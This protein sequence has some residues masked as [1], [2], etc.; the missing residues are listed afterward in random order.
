MIPKA[1]ITEWK[2]FSPFSTKLRALYQRR[3]G[4]D[5]FDLWYAD[6]VH[7]L[8]I[9]NIVEGFHKYITNDGLSISSNDFIRNVEEKLKDNEFNGAIAGLIRPQIIYDGSEAWLTIK[10][11]LINFL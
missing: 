8:E 11:L 9:K 5:L 6:Q 4:R 1:Y 10:N 7:N 2:N 3:K